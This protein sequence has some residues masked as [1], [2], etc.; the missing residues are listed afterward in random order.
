MSLKSILGMKSKEEK[1]K[2]QEI[3]TDKAFAIHEIVE[4]ARERKELKDK[5]NELR[6]EILVD[7]KKDVDNVLKEIEVV[8]QALSVNDR[9]LQDTTIFLEEEMDVEENGMYQ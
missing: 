3:V 5:L 9:K 2:E 7:I 4:L 1:K 6:N 8:S